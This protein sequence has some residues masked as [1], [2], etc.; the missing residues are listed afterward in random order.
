MPKPNTK[1]EGDVWLSST[2][3]YYEEPEITASKLRDI[4]DNVYGRGLSMKLRHL[5]F[6][7]RYE[8]EVYNEKDER[9]EELEKVIDAMTNTPENNFWA[10]MQRAYTDIFWYGISIFNPVWSY[11]GSEFR[12]MKLRH[13]PALSFEDAPPTTA[14]TYSEILQG[15]TLDESKQKIEYWQTDSDGN[16]IQIKN[17]F[18]VKDPVTDKIGGESIILPLVPIIEMLDFVWGAQMQQANRTGAKILF[19]KITNPKPANAQNN[20]VGDKEYGAMLLQKWGKDQAFILRDNM[21]LIDPGI[22]DDLSNL[23]VID[24]LAHI[25]IDYITPTAMIAREGSTI[26]GSELQREELLNKYIAGVHSWIQNQ[27]ES[28]LNEYLEYNGYEN[29]RVEIVIPEPT[30]DRSEMDLKEAEVGFKTHS[31]T[32]NEIRKRLGEAELEEE[33]LTNLIDLYKNLSPP[34]QGFEAA[35]ME[36]GLEKNLKK[37]TIEK[38]EKTIERSIEEAAEILAKD[39]IDALKHEE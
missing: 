12:L 31:L 20:S 17:V 5:I 2:G 7:D 13:L 19:L 23:E 11:E 25:L 33:E 28:L 24:A 1:E 32:I 39:I 29:Y 21:E 26:G 15:I 8:I 9:D 10:N 3:T 27:F 14:D 4:R 6:R 18:V 16:Q 22:K 37:Q 38:S 34:A 30:I 36:T 35:K